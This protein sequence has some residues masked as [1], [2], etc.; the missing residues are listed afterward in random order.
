MQ[1]NSF[2]VEMLAREVNMSRSQL[3]R[4]LQ[5]LTNKSATEFIRTFRLGRAMEMI[6]QKAGS[7]AEIGYKV[8]FSSPSY[9]N[10]LFLQYYGITPGQVKANLL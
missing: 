8:G 6:M 4:K 7:I 10:K 1:D 3:H 9:F 2:S 5:A